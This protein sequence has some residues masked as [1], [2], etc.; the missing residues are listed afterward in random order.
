MCEQVLEQRTLFP[1]DVDEVLLVG[2][3]SR[4]PL[5]RQRAE[6]FFVQ[7]PVYLDEPEPSVVLGA[8]RLSTSAS[9][10]PPSNSGA[11]PGARR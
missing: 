11:A 8:A 4:M 1:G 6:A 9:K 5:F 7:M 3:Q 10:P 2:E